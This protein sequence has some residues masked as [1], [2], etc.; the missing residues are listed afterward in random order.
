MA[1]ASAA[2]PIDDGKRR[3]RSPA[4]PYINLE[5]AIK[6]AKEFY[7]KEQRNAANLRVAIKHWGYEE[8]SSGGTQTIAAMLSFGLLRDDG[9]GEKRRVQLT[10]LALRILLD[11]RQDSKER[12]EAIKQSALAPKIHQQLW[13]RWGANRPSDEGLRHTLILDWT[14]PFN[15]NTVDVFIREY[16]DTIAF[17]KLGES[18]R[19]PVEV[20]DSGGE[21]I[22]AYTPK[23]GDY[24][25][26]DHNGVL[27]FAE[28]K[29]VKGFSPDGGYA[30]I[31]GQNGAVPVKELLQESAPDNTQ[32][33]SEVHASQRIQPPLK[34]HMDEMI[35]PLSRGT[36]ATF[37][38]PSSLTQADVDDLKDSLKIV[39]RKIA[40]SVAE[41]KPPSPNPNA[42]E[43]FINSHPESNS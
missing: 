24:V 41:D 4:Y 26:W 22:Q 13:Q 30:F 19:V 29:R 3:L 6:R 25:Q 14:P 37:Q 27:G 5:A 20:E 10:P 28:P 11:T 32:V 2:V 43:E 17:A 36:K 33:R 15:E 7:D 35:V 39:E 18:D 9:T 8:K 38:W 34:T 12:A 40:R 23:V 21:K 42:V 16:K 31:D 1:Q